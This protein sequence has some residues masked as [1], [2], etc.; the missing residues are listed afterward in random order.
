MPEHASHA[1]IEA[2]WQRIRAAG[3]DEDP[4]LAQA[5][6]VLGDPLNRAAYDRSRR[7]ELEAAHPPFEPDPVTDATPWDAPRP[8]N[9]RARL[10][11][12]VPNEVVVDGDLPVAVPFV[13]VVEGSGM[14]RA[15]VRADHPGLSVTAGDLV[16][17][18]QLP[19]GRH[20]LTLHVQP[21]LLGALP[22]AVTV[23]FVDQ[24]RTL[25][26]ALRVRQAASPAS[27]QRQVRERIALALAG[28]GLLLVGWALGGGTEVRRDSASPTSVGRLDRQLPDVMRCFADG[29]SALPAYV[30]VH[31]DG[32]G[33]T[34]GFSFGDAV[35]GPAAHG[36][37]R[38]ALLALEFPP[39]ADGGNAFHRYGL[40]ARAP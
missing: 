38:R 9:A 2:A 14:Y 22:A 15:L 34:T 4:P 16:D 33:R 32:F 10:S 5:W 1:A 25:H 23:S 7:A 3:R 24:A 26:L 6:R 39:T 37:V 17:H 27:R 8:G 35:V 21:R 19:A 30:D 31:T 20:T 28:V 11:G 18:V 12:T 13:L 36:C 29:R 40:P